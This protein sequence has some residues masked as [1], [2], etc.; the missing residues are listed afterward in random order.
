MLPKE[1]TKPTDRK[2]QNQQTGSPLTFSWETK[3]VPLQSPES[4]EK[5]Y[6]KV[7]VLS[8]TESPVSPSA[9][10]TRREEMEEG[11]PGNHLS[12]YTQF[13]DTAIIFPY[14]Q[15]IQKSKQIFMMS[16]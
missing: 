15:R 5:S 8:R 4:Y 7:L 2:W 3:L 1:M 14:Q 9:N 6:V 13:G 16:D 12:N 10:W 11:L